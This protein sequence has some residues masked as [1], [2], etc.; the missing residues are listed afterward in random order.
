MRFAPAFVAR[1]RMPRLPLNKG[2]FAGT[3]SDAPEHVHSPAALASASAVGPRLHH[4]A[5]READRLSQPRGLERVARRVRAGG[6]RDTIRPPLAARSALRDRQRTQ[7]LVTDPGG[8]GIEP[9]T[10]SLR[11]HSAGASAV[12]RRAAV[13]MR[14]SGRRCGD[15]G[16]SRLSN[17]A[18]VLSPGGY[19][20]AATS[21]PS[22]TPSSNALISN[23]SRSSVRHGLLA[24]TAI[25]SAAM[26][27]TTIGTPLPR[28]VQRTRYRPTSDNT[29]P[30]SRMG[31]TGS[32]NRKMPATAMMAAPPARIAGTADS[33]PPR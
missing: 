17:A 25:I 3:P 24:G 16:L 26:S 14:S 31:R 12:M 9:P 27:V 18:G 10:S 20:R 11:G 8:T 2:L 15:C 13:E 5:A 32:S 6:G 22:S 4:R 7:L 33:G 21:T 28:K 1:P 29:I 23:H 30:R 19:A